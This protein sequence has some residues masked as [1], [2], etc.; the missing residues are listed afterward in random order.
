MMVYDMAVK[1]TE[2]YD[3]LANQFPE[4]DKGMTAEKLMELI[5]EKLKQFDGIE[6]KRWLFL[7]TPTSLSPLFEIDASPV[8]LS[9]VDA[10]AARTAN[11]GGMLFGIDCSKNL[12]TPKCKPE[13]TLMAIVPEKE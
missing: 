11:C 13:I 7:Y 5:Q 9:M 8:R 12:G 2:E 10:K 1:F 3:E 4:D 6:S